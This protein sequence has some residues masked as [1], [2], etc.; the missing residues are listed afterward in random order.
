[1]GIEG[2]GHSISV[3]LMKRGIPIGELFDNSGFPASRTLLHY[4]D[5]LLYQCRTKKE[6]LQGICLTL[7]PGSFTSMRVSLSVAEA[8][9][10]GLHIPL[11]GI[12]ELTLTANTLPFYPF[13]IKVVKN[14]YKGE[15]YTASFETADGTAKR[16]DELNL[17]TPRRF[18][19]DLRD[20]ELVLGNGLDRVLAENS[21]SVNRRMRWN[22]SFSRQVG[23]IDVIE[24]FLDSGAR[25]P[26]DIPLEPIYVRLSEAELNYRA[27][28][29][30]FA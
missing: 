13:P 21:A 23:G 3:G 17:V 2:S 16:L 26:S 18:L 12:D 22:A 20:N 9:G 29:G 19:Q 4:I 1:M 27:R 10:L 14:A 30:P 25:E 7:G 15:I 6:E 24:Y 5:T 8:I 11:Y 28:F